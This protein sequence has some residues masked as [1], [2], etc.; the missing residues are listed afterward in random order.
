MSNPGILSKITSAERRRLSDLTSVG[1]INLV[2]LG[3][4]LRGTEGI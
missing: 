1:A 4:S 2:G 3:G